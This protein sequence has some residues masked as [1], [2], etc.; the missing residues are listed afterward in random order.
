MKALFCRSAAFFLSGLLV[1][2]TMA[3]P[4]VGWRADG[5]GAYPDADPPTEW[6][7]NKN[8]VWKTKLPGNSFGSPLVLE[9][10]IFVVSDP[11]ELLCVNPADGKVLWQRSHSLEEL[12]DAETA[13]KVTAEFKRFKD[14]S[15][16]LRREM[17]K[18]KDDKERKEEFKKQLEAVEKE[19]DDLLKK[20]PLPPAI[21][22]RGSGNSAPTPVSDGKNVYAAFGNGIVCAYTLDGE[23]LWVKYLEY[24]KLGFGHANSPVLIDGKLLV[25]FKD[26]VALD[27][28]TG[29]PVWRTA[30]EARYATPVPVEVG[31]TAA[32][33]DPIGAVVRVSD[34]K[35]LL[36]HG[37][38]GASECSLIA[39]RGLLYTT[40]GQARALR[41]IPA[42]DDA[43]KLEQLWQ[44]KDAGGR[45]TPSPVLHDGVLYGVTTEG[46]LDA[47]DAK[48]GEAL[49]REKLNIG[50]VYA[51][52]TLAGKYLFFGSTKGATVVIEAGREYKEVARN[53]LEG[54]GSCPVFSG[55]R[56]YLRTN[57]YLYCIGK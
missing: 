27:A 55:Q 26:L 36:R 44:T 33:V 20:Y 49:Y 17:D 21:E 15:G 5:S 38:L 8:V 41:L 18:A 34:G 13:R 50:E 47:F 7:E 46:T 42:G 14:E 11:A 37:S 28:Q 22:N 39:H 3:A 35:V 16:R 10:Q 51:S 56:M 6:S 53:Q 52:A 12:F 43:V 48:T 57:K 23:R 45:R 4:P 9:K 19:Q 24:S 40:E 2:S 29:E 31:T 30:L 25:H 32:V 1:A 54:Y